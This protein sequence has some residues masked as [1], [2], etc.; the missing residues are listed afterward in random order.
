MVRALGTKYITGEATLDLG[1]LIECMASS[2]DTSFVTQE[3]WFA[4][5]LNIQGLL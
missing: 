3:P 5:E 2:K 1:P 4:G